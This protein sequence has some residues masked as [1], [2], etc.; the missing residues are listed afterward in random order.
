MTEFEL[1][2]RQFRAEKLNAFQQLHVMRR[3]T[4]LLVPMLEI[5]A[6][7]G[8]G[9]LAKKMLAKPQ[10][11]SPLLEQLAGLPDEALEYV[12]VTCL[13]AL[14]VQTAP[15]TWVPLWVPVAKRAIVDDLNDLGKLLPLVARVIQEDL[16]G[17]FGALPTLLP[18]QIGGSPA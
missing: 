2:G 4:P 14:K 9:A 17:F 6:L 8:D 13:G 18:S 11:L 1:N 7:A 3:I 5:I 10:V 15:G 16:G 12:M